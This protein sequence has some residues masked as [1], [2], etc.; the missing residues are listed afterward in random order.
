MM[1]QPAYL[2][3]LLA[4]TI[5]VA[6]HLLSRKEGRVI[7]VG[8]LRHLQETASQQFRG[9]KLNELLL[10]GLRLWLLLLFVLL[11]AGFN[12][13]TSNHK[14]VVYDPALNNHPEARAFA[15]SLQANGYEWHWFTNG[16]PQQDQNPEAVQNYWPVINELRTQAVSEAI[17]VSA[18]LLKNFNGSLQ[19]LPTFITWQTFELPEH[20][21]DVFAVKQNNHNIVRRG[22][23]NSTQTRFVTDTVTTLPD[24]VFML[25]PIRVAINSDSNFESEA[26]LVAAS[27]KAIQTTVPLEIVSAEVNNADWVIWLSGKTIPD[28]RA[29]QIA[30]DNAPG[31]ILEQTAPTKWIIHELTIDRAVQENFTVQLAALLTTHAT[32]ER[33]IA[34]HDRRSIPDLLTTSN[35]AT[36]TNKASATMSWPLLIVFILSL[37]AERIVAFIRKQ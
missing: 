8:S 15:D 28:T 6:I 18:S 4:L 31:K 10:L 33:Q 12:W 7:P 1:A 26:Q 22:T 20:K 24:S 13:N 29:N 3:A 19:T 17:V 14:W 37:L 16:F 30:I 27:L 25:A 34:L 5:P 35:Q 23:S 11:L 36:V 21:F 9:I 2:W 32:A